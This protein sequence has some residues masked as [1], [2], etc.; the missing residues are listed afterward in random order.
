MINYND[1]YIKNQSLLHDIDSIIFDCDGVLIDI[2]NSYDLT[3]KQ[4]VY[5][6]LKNMNI[7]I[8]YFDNELLHRIIG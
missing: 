5:Y 7:T 2:T 6:I 3:I 8:S 4:T 1:V